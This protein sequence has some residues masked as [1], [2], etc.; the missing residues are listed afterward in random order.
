MDANVLRLAT[1]FGSLIVCLVEHWHFALDLNQLLQQTPAENLK[2]A[3]AKGRHRLK[4][5]DF[6]AST[7]QDKTC[8]RMRQSILRGEVDDVTQLSAVRFK[9]LLAGRDVEEEIA[10]RERGSTC[11][12]Y[13]LNSSQTRSVDLNGSTDFTTFVAGFKQQATHT[14]DAGQSFAAK[15]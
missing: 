13:L 15:A 3:L 14:G 11:T 12:G 2:D 1:R 5:E 8:F 6:R 9:K 10:H 7:P 4:V